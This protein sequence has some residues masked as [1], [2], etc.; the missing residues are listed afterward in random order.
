M[1]RIEEERQEFD[2]IY[3]MKSGKGMTHTCI[4]LFGYPLY[5]VGST[6]AFDFMKEFY[7]FLAILR[8]S[9]KKLI[10]ICRLVLPPSMRQ[11]CRFCF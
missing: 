10:T 5:A 1:Y 6:D 11:G 3:R 8:Q 4:F 9:M 2:R 7:D